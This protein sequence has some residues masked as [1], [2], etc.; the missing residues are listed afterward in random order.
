MPGTVWTEAPP[1]MEFACACLHAEARLN[2]VCSSNGGPPHKLKLQPTS[3]GAC[4]WTGE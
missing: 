4:S 1:H 2:G 3:I